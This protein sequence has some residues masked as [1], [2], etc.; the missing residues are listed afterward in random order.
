MKKEGNCNKISENLKS[1]A[2]KI[3]N[4]TTSENA[5]KNSKINGIIQQNII[6]RQNC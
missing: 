3:N 5:S 6:Q 4:K 1:M 2:G